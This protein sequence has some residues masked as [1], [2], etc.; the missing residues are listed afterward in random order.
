MFDMY[1]LLLISLQ[2]IHPPVLRLA[3]VVPLHIA[4]AF[5]HLI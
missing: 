5:V 1:L 4:L 3:I 2:L